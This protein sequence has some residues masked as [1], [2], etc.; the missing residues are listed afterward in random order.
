MFPLPF[1]F[2]PPYQLP[3]FGVM[4]NVFDDEEIDRV[5]FYEKILDFHPAEI[6]GDVNSD[7]GQINESRVC[8]I[9][10]MPQDENTQWLWNKIAQLTAKANYDLFMYDIEFLEDLNYVVYIG[11]DNGKY[12]QHRD[13]SLF[14]Y[15][16]YDRKI[17]GIMMLS[18]PEEYS[19]GELL[20]DVQGGA[21]K[22]KWIDVKLKKGD[23]V[24]FD[25]NFIHCVEPVTSG[26]RQVIVFWAHGKVKV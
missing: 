18:E 11:D 7:E 21:P 22:E 17:S 5:R 2:A 1:T 15:R 19:G 14:G 24:F 3:H 9:S 20:I 10:S 13:T 16:K 8:E 26:N 4:E 23:V 6:L 12:I 25:S